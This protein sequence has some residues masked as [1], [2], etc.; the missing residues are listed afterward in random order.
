MTQRRKM[1][2]RGRGWS[3]RVCVCVCVCVCMHACV[4]VYVCTC[5]RGYVHM[6]MHVPMHNGGSCGVWEGVARAYGAS[7]WLSFTARGSSP[8][9]ETRGV[10]QSS[11]REV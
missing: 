2:P 11:C 9:A 1:E 3:C 6:P 10:N 7:E 8:H 5:T 4:C